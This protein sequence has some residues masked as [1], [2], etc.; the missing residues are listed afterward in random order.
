MERF[1]QIVNSK[2]T[3]DL[4]E[5]TLDLMYLTGFLIRLCSHVQCLLVCI[6]CYR[7]SSS[8]LFSITPRQCSDSTFQFRLWRKS[9][10]REIDRAC[11]GVDLN[12]N[13]DYRWGGKNHVKYVMPNDIFSKTTYTVEY[14]ISYQMMRYN[15]N[16]DKLLYWSFSMAQGSKK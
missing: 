7:K 11:V 12:R 4:F 5:K 13:F 6:K 9:R 10:S 1:V 16:S 8:D 15:Q 14:L 3:V 2:K